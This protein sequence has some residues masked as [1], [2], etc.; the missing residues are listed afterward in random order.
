MDKIFDIENNIVNTRAW[1]HDWIN[2]LSV[3]LFLVKS[4][5][6]QELEH[7][8]ENLTK[9]IKVLEK[10]L[11]NVDNIILKAIISQKIEIA[12]NFGIEFILKL[13]IPE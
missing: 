8:I 12:K 10:Q 3:L 11:L 4:G 5:E 6:Y 2:H 7:Y 9:E 13:D 1:Q